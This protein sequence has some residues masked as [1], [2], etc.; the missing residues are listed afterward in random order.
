MRRAFF[1]IALLASLV[2]VALPVS[3]Q[4]SCPPCPAQAASTA[5]GESPGRG[6]L[7]LNTATEAELV[8]LPGVG[9]SKAKAI[10]AFREARG[11]FHSVSQLL[12]IKGF[13]R[14]T[15]ERLRPLVVVESAP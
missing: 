12:R 6:P 5:S 11:R 9:P 4:D 7:N 15:V 2:S 10:L 13:G 8:T 1:R 3:A 14:A